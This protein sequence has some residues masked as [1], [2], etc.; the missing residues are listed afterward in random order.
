MLFQFA[1]SEAFKVCFLKKKKEPAHLWQ[2]QTLL[3][4]DSKVRQ[5]DR[6]TDGHLY[7]VNLSTSAPHPHPGSTLSSSDSTKLD[8]AASPSLSVCLYV[9]SHSKELCLSKVSGGPVCLSGQ[10]MARRRQIYAQL[11]SGEISRVAGSAHSLPG[12]RSSPRKG[13][14]VSVCVCF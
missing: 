8:L 13:V 3:W 4:T 9:F 2:T 6:W 10:S 12:G 7:P 1:Y 5:T 14:C 11:C